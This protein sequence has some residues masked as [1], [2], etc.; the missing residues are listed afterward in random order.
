MTFVGTVSDAI[1]DHGGWKQRFRISVLAHHSDLPVEIVCQDN[2]CAFGHWLY[3][4]D[5]HEK[6][7][8]RWNCVRS[9]HADFHR[10]AARILGLA[11]ECKQ[12]EALAALRFPSKFSGLS[13]QLGKELDTWKRELM[14]EARTQP[15]GAAAQ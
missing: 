14:R 8:P 13:A 10:E 7:T 3:S 9:A 12:D 15:A 2:R 1:R 11:L 6:A 4:L 5:E